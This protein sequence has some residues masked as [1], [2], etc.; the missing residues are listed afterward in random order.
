MVRIREDREIDFT[1]YTIFEM[2][3]AFR[4]DSIKSRSNYWKYN[5]W[6]L[7]YRKKLIKALQKKWTK[8]LP[9]FELFK[10]CI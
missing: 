5:W 8:D 3:Q 9:D 7:D 10:F 1:C 6:R 2:V 4:I